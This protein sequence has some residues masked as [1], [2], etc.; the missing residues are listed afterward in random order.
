L[1]DFVIRYDEPIVHFR[2]EL[3]VLDENGVL[4]QDRDVLESYGLLTRKSLRVESHH[5]SFAIDRKLFWDL[6]GYAE[7]RIGLPYPQGEDSDFWGKCQE[8]ARQ[9]GVRTPDKP[10]TLYVFPT[11]RWC[12]DVDHNPQGLFHNLSRKTRKNYWW[13]R[14]CKQERMT[15]AEHAKDC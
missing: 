12:G 2:R 8:Y 11:S 9:N 10:P 5:N 13:N 15:A 14:Q 6:G 4:T 7:D 3:G 1:I